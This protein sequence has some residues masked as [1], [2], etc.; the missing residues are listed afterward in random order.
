MASGYKVRLPDGSE[1][2]PLSIE[3]VKDW[4]ARGLIGRDSPV[5][6][7]NGSR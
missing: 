4:F 3:E 6:R 2:G 7:P 5:M 1:I